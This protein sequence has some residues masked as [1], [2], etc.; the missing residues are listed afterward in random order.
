[1]KTLA[2]VAVMTLVCIT[3]AEGHSWYPHDCCHDNDCKP[4]PCNELI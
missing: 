4:V 2:I 1:M 3:E